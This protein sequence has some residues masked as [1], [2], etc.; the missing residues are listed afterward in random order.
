M[1]IAPLPTELIIAWIDQDGDYV[2]L[3]Q[4]A[5]A[6]VVPDDISRRDLIDFVVGS[7]EPGLRSGAIR[8]GRVYHLE[9]KGRSMRLIGQSTR[10]WIAYGRRSRP[11]IRIG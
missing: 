2:N 7:I 1:R 9:G 4:I 5:Q 10:C 11:I 8:A 3:W 6:K